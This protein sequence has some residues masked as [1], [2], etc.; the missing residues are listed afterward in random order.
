LFEA[1]ETTQQALAKSL[2]KLLDR[3]C[4]RKKIIVYV[5]TKGSNL[6]AMTNAFKFVVCCE[7]LNLEESFQ[8]YCFGHAFS[9]A[10]QY[11]KIENKCPNI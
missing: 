11:A 4:L 9:K 5:K 6:N 10:Y 8:G 7:I 3:Y 1:L 2:T